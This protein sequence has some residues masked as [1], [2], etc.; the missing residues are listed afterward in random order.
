MVDYR[1]GS[2]G[3][4]VTRIQRR[5]AELGLYTGPLD[6][7]F[8]GGTASAVKALQARE[9]LTVDGVVGSETW[10]VLFQQI[11][12]P[13][14]AIFGESLAYRCLALTG[15]FETNASPPDCFC[16]ISGDFDDQGMSLGVLQWNFGQGS[17]QPL[18][19]EFMTDYPDVA[20]R[21][22]QDDLQVV[23][24]ALAA[25]HDE[26]MGFVRSIQHP[27][28]HAI[29]EPW[30]GMARTLGRTEEF[31][32]LQVKHASQFFER[33]LALCKVYGLKSER[34]VMLMFD[35]CVQNGSISELVKTR[36]VTDFNR[37]PNGLDQQEMEIRKM[38]IIANRR[39][40]AANP[41]WVEDV[42]SRKLTIANGEGVVHGVR[43]DLANQYG[44]TLAAFSS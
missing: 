33:A 21:V 31:Q 39:A 35:I 23:S 12:M 40:E 29:N 11:E 10:R 2:F 32:R 4:A 36:I 38:Q 41:R 8:G 7:I 30:R 9:G 28:K 19:Q 22:F 34:A 42:R 5:L 14:P 17:L 43:I 24:A 3:D 16:A 27:I 13:P 44:I 25:P 20:K 37:L 18:L 6:G 1:L 15:S 26:L